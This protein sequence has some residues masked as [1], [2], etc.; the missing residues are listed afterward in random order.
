M[1]LNNY[2]IYKNLITYCLEYLSCKRV[3]QLNIYSLINSNKFKWYYL[4]QLYSKYKIDSF[5][6][7][8]FDY[9]FEYKLYI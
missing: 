6:P 9:K 2:N 1:L 8:F 7:N 3:M 4:F 5:K